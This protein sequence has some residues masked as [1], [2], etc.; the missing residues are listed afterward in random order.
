LWKTSIK[1]FIDHRDSTREEK[2]LSSSDFVT[3]AR[4][5]QK[6]VNKWT[7]NSNF[8]AGEHSRGRLLVQSRFARLPRL[9]YTSHSPAAIIAPIH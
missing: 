8:Q 6:L 4:M 7:L 5:V 9:I 3:A 1:I 2:R